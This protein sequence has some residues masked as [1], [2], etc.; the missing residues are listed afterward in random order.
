MTIIAKRVVKLSCIGC[1][2]ACVGDFAVMFFLGTYDPGYSELKDTM[3][4]LGASISPVAD[5][6]SRW[7]IIFGVLFIFFGIGFKQA[8]TAKGKNASVA[9]LLIMLYGIGE[10]IG[11][12]V[13]KASHNSNSLITSLLHEMLGAIGIV[14]LLILPVVMKRLISKIEHPYFHAL[15][16][17]V[18]FTGILMLVLFLFRYSNDKNNFLYIY[19]GLWQRLLMLNNYIY[20][21]TIAVIMYKKSMYHN[22]NT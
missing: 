14:S 1:I 4:A 5:E 21:V 9:S 18:F 13:F 12:G 2:I 11:S 15:S 22:E 19:Q 3:S 17:M 20:L 8:F 10:G 16:S 7:W 6:I